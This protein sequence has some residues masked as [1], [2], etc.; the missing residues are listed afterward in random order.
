MLVRPRGLTRPDDLIGLRGVEHVQ[1]PHGHKP[2]EAR[3][4]R[5]LDRRH[6]PPRPAPTTPSRPNERYRP[7]RTGRTSPPLQPWSAPA[8]RGTSFHDPLMAGSVLTLA[9]PQGIPCAG[10]APCRALRSAG[11][12]SPDAVRRGYWAAAGRG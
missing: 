4:R 10:C 5:P 6:H 1:L 2:L 11:P 12:S 9:A 8:V 3:I 7:R